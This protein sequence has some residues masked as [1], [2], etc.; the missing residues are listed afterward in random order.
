MSYVSMIIQFYDW[1]INVGSCS[2]IRCTAESR[3]S[4]SFFRKNQNVFFFGPPQKKQKSSWRLRQAMNLI[5]QTTVARERK[6]S[7]PILLVNRTDL[8]LANY[9]VVLAPRFLVVCRCHT[10][11][12]AGSSAAPVA[13]A[14]VKLLRPLPCQT[15][16]LPEAQAGECSSDGVIRERMF[17]RLTKI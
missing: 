3:A 13:P 8:A 17:V 14:T 5:A 4:C 6:R 7:V 1:N 15:A 2:S 9:S 12:C 16:S 10:G 11:L